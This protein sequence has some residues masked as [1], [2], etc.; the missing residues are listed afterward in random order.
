[1]AAAAAEVATETSAEAAVAATV[2][3]AVPPARR[4]RQPCYQRNERE[5]SVWW[6]SA[7][8]T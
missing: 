2:V 8:V 5:G 6:Q 4:Y 3:K 1:V 7:E